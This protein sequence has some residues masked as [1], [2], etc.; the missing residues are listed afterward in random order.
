MAHPGPAGT[1]LTRSDVGREP[2]A[3][4]L[5]TAAQRR[6][7]QLGRQAPHVAILYGP[8]SSE[9][10]AYFDRLG[11]AARSTHD[12]AGEIQR[13]TCAPVTLIDVSASTRWFEDLAG[14]DLVVV[15]LHGSPGEDGTVQGF[16][17]TRGLRFVGSDVEASVL[18]L[19][20]GATKLLAIALGVPTP[21]FLVVRDS[22]PVIGAL[23]AHVLRICK[24][25][26]GGSSLDARLIAAHAA[27]PAEGE[28]LVEEYVAGEDV[29]VTVVE[30]EGRPVALPAVVL[31][32][33]HPIYDAD[34]KLV[35]DPAHKARA[36]RPT[37]LLERLREC[38]ELAVQMHR[39]LGV[40]HVSR[41]D[42]VVG[43]AGSSYLETNTL[44]GLSALSNVTE[45]ARAGGIDY[46]ALVALVVG[47]AL[48]G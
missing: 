35:S 13:L 32:H 31:R 11:S 3:L 25:L 18:A 47:A 16:L 7:E 5:H 36:V 2:V 42:F 22:E 40:A 46:T 19:N 30:V 23:G 34:V 12:L 9:D 38:E 26:R 29:T 41:S 27:W 24:P 1:G 45:C 43:D 8:A 15:N 14:V 4:D 37:H 20:K 33:D 6:R 28:W 21:A 10:R 48:D 44:P 39:G 17:R